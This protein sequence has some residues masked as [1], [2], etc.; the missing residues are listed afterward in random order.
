[1]SAFR[2]RAGRNAAAYAVSNGVKNGIANGGTAA[3]KNGLIDPHFQDV[4]LHKLLELIDSDPLGKIQDWAVALNLSQSHLQHLFKRATGLGLGHLLTEKR[5]QKAAS[6]LATTSLSIKEIS[7]AVG[8]EHASSF[9][10]AFERRFEQG[11]RSYRN[12]PQEILA[13]RQAS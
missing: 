13:E 10:R 4:R 2:S 8:Y 5:L 3:L 1:M 9:T 6:L 11:P 7:C 12:A